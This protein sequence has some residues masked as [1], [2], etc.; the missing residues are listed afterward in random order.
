MTDK[1]TVLPPG[2]GAPLVNGPPRSV[3]DP[4]VAIEGRVFVAG[5]VSRVRQV[6]AG[7]GAAVVAGGVLAVT[8]I[9]GA[10][11]PVVA[12]AAFALAAV[13]A[14]P[15]VRPVA[16]GSEPAQIRDAMDAQLRTVAGRVPNE[17]YGKLT[18]IHAA[19]LELIPRV[20]RLPPGSEDLYILRRIP[21]EYLPTTLETYL[22]LPREYAG[23]P[24]SPGSKAPTDQ[25]LEQLGLLEGKLAEI[26]ED[27]SAADASRLAAN[28]RFLRERFGAGALTPGDA[29]QA[30]TAG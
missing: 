25:L 2:A 21:L 10:F 17:V 28:G 23:R 12:V 15:T 11:W 1:G 9:V 14:R 6:V 7:I 26:S 30:L 20:D 5:P 4:A 8:G 16:R 24:A 27:I 3:L 13:L 22:A 29:P 18:S 19:I